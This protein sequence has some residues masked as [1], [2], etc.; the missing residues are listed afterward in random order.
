MRKVALVILAASFVAMFAVACGSGTTDACV[1]SFDC[2]AGEVCGEL[3]CKESP[4]NTKAD[5]QSGEFCFPGDRVGKDAQW[6]YCS[7]PLCYADQPCLEDAGLVCYPAKACVDINTECKDGLCEVKTTTGDTIEDTVEADVPRED[8]VV[9]ADVVPEI[10]IPDEVKDCATCETNVDCGA[11]YSCQPVGAEKHCLRECADDGNCEPGYICYASGGSKSCLPVSYSCPTCASDTPCDEGMCCDLNSGACKACKAECLSCTYDYDCAADLRCY[12]ETG[13]P[14]GVCVPECADG[15]CPDTA[16]Q[17]CT[18][19]GKGVKMCVPTG[20]GCKGCEGDTPYPLEDGTCV[21]CLTSDNCEGDD[22]CDTGTHTCEVSTCS[23][24][25]KMCDDGECKQCCVDDDCLEYEEATGYCLPEGTCEGVV[26]CGGLCTAD[27][28]ICA[29]VQGVEQ[30]VQCKVDADCALVGP[31]CTCTGDPIYSCVDDV[32]AI[33]QKEGSCAAMCTTDID[34][35]PASTG[36]SL[37][38]AQVG[39]SGICYDPAGTCDGSSACCAPGQ[40]CFD[41]I[42]L[43]FGVMGGGG[44]PMEIPSTGSG[45]CACDADNPCL[46]GKTCT[47]MSILCV[48]GSLLAGMGDLI[49]PGGQ[50]SPSFPQNMCFDIAD[51]LGGI[52]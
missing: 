14:T 4:C 30:C 28:P 5:C 46:S 17:A 7:A 40:K 33:C 2:P 38:C 6:K 43:L 25:T 45:Y 9:T 32:G 19:N 24:G 12:K 42:V 11:G 49:C 52:F 1:T 34:C 16:T 26:Q 48:L 31:A 20:E 29:I 8:T 44:M 3:V 13:S 21:E 10:I 39:G 27:F 47:D 37:A 51:I 50:L 22:E 23:T 18:D 35:P 15:T 41:L 36:A